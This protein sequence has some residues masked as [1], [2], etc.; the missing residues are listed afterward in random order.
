M[1]GISA[2]EATGKVNTPSPVSAVAPE[3][4]AA[5]EAGTEAD[6]KAAAALAVR[7]LEAARPPAM[8]TLTRKGFAGP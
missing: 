7:L 8:P 4:A 1:F 3:V 5:A 6:R 2:S